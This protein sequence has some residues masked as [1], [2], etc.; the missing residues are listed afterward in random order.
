RSGRCGPP[1]ESSGTTRVYLTEKEGRQRLLCDRRVPAEFVSDG[2]YASRLD[3][4]GE[5]L[6]IATVTPQRICAAVYV[7]GMVHRIKK[8]A[9]GARDRRIFRIER[10][11]GAGEFLPCH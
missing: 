4:A 6:E 8:R 1:A 9:A 5:P 7:G 11:R 10:T 2:R 3:E